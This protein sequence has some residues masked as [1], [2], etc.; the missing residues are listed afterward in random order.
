MKS[1]YPQADIL[2]SL[3]QVGK[4]NEWIVGKFEKSLGKNILELGAGLG[5]IT[6]KVID[7]G[8]NI[9]PSDINSYFLSSLKKIDKNS[10]F[11]NIAR[12]TPPKGKY[13][14]II[15][16]NVLEHIKN[17]NMAFKNIYDSLQDEGILVV[18]VP[19][20]NFLFG[21]Y[22]RIVNH[23]RRYSKEELRKKLEKTGF[24]IEQISYHN[25]LSALGWFVNAR[26]LKK[27]S[28][29]KFQLYIVNILVPLIDIIDRVIPFDFGIS[30]ICIAKKS[31][32]SK[33]CA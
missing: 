25:K 3:A 17:D 19:A 7:R 13:D 28:F 30:V 16:I 21:S 33:T 5:N 15:A 6:I 32:K 14:T 12:E 31:I 27:R 11:L 18:L 9:T 20:H 4:Y 23:Y 8:F 24:L 26:I 22:D 2:E 10:F 1:H 29:S